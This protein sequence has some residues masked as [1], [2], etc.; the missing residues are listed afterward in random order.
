M[1]EDAD[2]DRAQPGT[3]PIILRFIEKIKAAR[4]AKLS[5]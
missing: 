1:V 2:P 3:S 5:S 4:A